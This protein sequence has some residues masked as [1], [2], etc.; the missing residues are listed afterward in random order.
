MNPAHSWAR[1][2]GEAAW[3]LIIVLGFNLSIF[4]FFFLPGWVGIPWVLLLG[5]GFLAWHLRVGRRRPVEAVPWEAAPSGADESFP[6]HRR[7]RIRT[8][9]TS[10]G[11]LF[12]ITLATLVLMLGVVQIIQVITGPLELYETPFQEGVLEYTESWVGF[13]T[14][15]LAAALVIP[16]IEE[17]VFRGRL[18]G[19][20]E[21]AWGRP[22]PALAVSSALFALLHAGGPHPLI[23]LVP[24]IM[25]I[26]FGLAVILSRS[27][28]PAVFLHGVW[29]GLMTLSLRAPEGLT[30]DAT[31]EVGDGAA[32]LWGAVMIVLGLA[33]WL[34]L[35][36][37]APGMSGE[38]G[39]ADLDTGEVEPEDPFGRETREEPWR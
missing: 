37:Q 33:G 10:T 26:L 17:F 11:W 23:L 16:M 34:H 27:I 31:P 20:L 2:V 35:A 9:V 7:L 12:G 39:N 15:A 25:G 21:E 14:F 30:D 28:W 29:N 18:Q 13:I 3:A 22:A 38:A 24:F 1:T 8:P 32:L 5:T 19:Y 4:A 36:R 6:L